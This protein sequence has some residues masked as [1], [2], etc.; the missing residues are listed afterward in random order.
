MSA[1]T[2]QF[3]TRQRTYYSED[4]DFAALARDDDDFA[5]VYNATGG[6]LDWQDPK[7]L[8]YASIEATSTRHEALLTSI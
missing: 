3:A 2:S 1:S 8:Q 6:H 4:I 7:T 5:A